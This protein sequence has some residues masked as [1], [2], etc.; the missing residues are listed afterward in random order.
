ME[1]IQYGEQEK[2]EQY[3]MGLCERGEIMYLFR[4]REEELNAL[5]AMLRPAIYYQTE[6]MLAKEGTKRWAK[7]EPHEEENA[8]HHIQNFYTIIVKGR[9][10]PH[11]RTIRSRLLAHE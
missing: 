8:G 9:G 3:L 7:I 10:L 6:Q 2:I 5:E 4:G 11:K 1:N